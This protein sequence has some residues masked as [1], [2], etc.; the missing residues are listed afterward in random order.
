MIGEFGRMPVSQQLPHSAWRAVFVVVGGV[1]LGMGSGSQGLVPMSVEIS[2]RTFYVQNQSS[3]HDFT[4][5]E[6]WHKQNLYNIGWRYLV[7]FNDFKAC[8]N[9]F[10]QVSQKLA[11]KA[12][13]YCQ[14]QLFTLPPQSYFPVFPKKSKQLLSS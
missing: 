5:L 6:V 7:L 2:I 10:Y 8:H 12:L 1:F 3:Q 9:S 13:H 14:L 4:G 11:A